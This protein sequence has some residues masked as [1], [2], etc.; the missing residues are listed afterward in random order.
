VRA[1]TITVRPDPIADLNDFAEVLQVIRALEPDFT[2]ESEPSEDGNAWI[3]TASWRAHRFTDS[4]TYSSILAVAPGDV[5][6]L[7]N[8]VIARLNERGGGPSC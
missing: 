6:K 3:V 7:L 4:W 1:V 8:H 2:L 5:V